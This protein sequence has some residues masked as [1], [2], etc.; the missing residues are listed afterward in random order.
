MVCVEK[1]CVHK[2]LLPRIIHTIII[3]LSKDPNSMDILISFLLLFLGMIAAGGGV[4]IKHLLLL[5]WMNRIVVGRVFLGEHKDTHLQLFLTT[6]LFILIAR[7]E[8]EAFS[9]PF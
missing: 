5:L 9:C 4:R 1:N 2:N 7:L 8:E 3:L 6:S